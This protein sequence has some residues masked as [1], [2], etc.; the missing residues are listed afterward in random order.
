M[1]EVETLVSCQY[2]AR[3]G[4]CFREEIQ[5]GLFSFIFKT[6]SKNSHNF[7]N[8]EIR[9]SLLELL[10]ES[11]HIY[12]DERRKTQNNIFKSYG[13]SGYECLKAIALDEDI[14][15]NIRKQAVFQIAASNRNNSAK[16]IADNFINGKDSSK[17][18]EAYEKG[19]DQAGFPLFIQSKECL[20]DLGYQ[21]HRQ[22]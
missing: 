22:L 17:L 21:V 6:K 13:K 11:Y 9:N 3:R 2:S 18:Y 5:M 10:E 20:E 7:T 1:E 15:V 16:F 8:L 4:F 14:H 12:D 19:I